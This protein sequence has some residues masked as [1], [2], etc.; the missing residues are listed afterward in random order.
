MQP[1]HNPIV[2]VRYWILISLASVL[3]TNTGDLA[4]QLFR[5]W[6]EATNAGWLGLKHIGPLPLLIFIFTLTYLAER[7]DKYRHEIYFW[8]TIIIIR[9]AATNIADTLAGDLKINFWLVT[10]ILSL[11]LVPLALQWQ[12]KRPR[13]LNFELDLQSAT[14]VSAT[15]FG[16]VAVF[17]KI[18]K[19]NIASV[20][21]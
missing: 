11:L 3:G 16:L 15:V 4:V 2:N 9:T 1:I 8:L 19:N 12:S 18:K 5:M 20:T 14:L 13:P 17:W 7:M 6:S 21:V 10:A